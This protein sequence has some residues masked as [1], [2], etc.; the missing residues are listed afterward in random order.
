MW[1]VSIEGN[2]GAVGI[3]RER[4]LH[5]ASV[6]MERL[7]SSWS[8]RQFCCL[9]GLWSA[10]LQMRRPGYAVLQTCFKVFSTSDLDAKK[11]LPLDARTELLVL[12]LISPQL[13]TNVRADICDLIG[14]TDASETSSGMCRVRVPFDAQIELYDRCEG[15]GEHVYLKLPY[16]CDQ[17]EKPKSSV[18]AC[19]LVGLP[20]QTLGASEFR[21]PEHINILEARALLQY[22]R[23]CVKEGRCVSG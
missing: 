14:A 13:E 4:R 7:H 5:L 15:K 20:W 11:Y 6:T 10:V 12:C 1:G 17:K 16:I 19:C 18:D 22:V 2:T 9:L 3:S 21:V 8:G 23:L